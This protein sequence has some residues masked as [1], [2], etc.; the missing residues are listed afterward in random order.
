MAKA[1]IAC[2]FCGKLN[3]VD[4]ARYAQGPKCAECSK[5][6]LLDHPVKVEEANFDAT[7]LGSEVPVLVDFYADW[8]GPCKAMAPALDEIASEKAGSLLVAKVDTDKSPQISIRYGIRGI[9]YFGLFQGGKLVK[10]AV[11]AVGKKGLLALAETVAAP[12]AE[13]PRRAAASG[14]K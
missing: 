2:Q 8:C 1:T 7:V 4:V 13:A 6:F 11:G 3:K 9:P 12:A 14:E 10:S 5:P